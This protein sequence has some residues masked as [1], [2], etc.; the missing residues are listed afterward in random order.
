MRA[1]TITVQTVRKCDGMR[2]DTEHVR[3]SQTRGCTRTAKRRNH[4]VSELR[5]ARPRVRLKYED[6]ARLIMVHAN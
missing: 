6:E 1:Y 2:G 5:L 4:S 3:S